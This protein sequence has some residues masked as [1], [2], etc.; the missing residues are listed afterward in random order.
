MRRKNRKPSMTVAD[1]AKVKPSEEARPMYE[2]YA[3][4]PAE[5]PGETHAELPAGH[6]GTKR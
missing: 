4:T 5:L 3:G 2:M 1:E 6:E